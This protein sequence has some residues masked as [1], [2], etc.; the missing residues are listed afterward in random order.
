MAFTVGDG[1]G[2]PTGDRRLALGA[3]VDQLP[4]VL[5]AIAFALTVAGNRWGTYLLTP[6]P[7]LFLADLLLV[8]G[9][10][11]ALLLH[12]RHYRLS[13]WALLSYGLILGYVVLILGLEFVFVP[14]QDRYFAVRDAAPFLYLALVPALAMALRRQ[15]A[16]SAVYFVRAVTALAVVGPLL[17]HVGLVEASPSFLLGSEQV[18]FFEYRTDL[19]GAVIAIGF[20]AWSGWPALG[21]RSHLTVQLIYAF[22]AG[23]IFLSR[24]GMVA[25]AVGIIVL[26]L[27]QRRWIRGSLV[28][29]AAL[30]LLLLGLVIGPWLAPR[31]EVSATVSAP[32]VETL[33]PDEAQGTDAAVALKD[34]AA[35]VV[36]PEGGWAQ[37]FGRVGTVAARLDTWSDIVTGMARDGTWVLGGAAGSDYLYELCTG[38][39]EAPTVL[40]YP[41][42]GPKCAVDDY[43]PEPVVRDPHNWILNIAITHGVLG[44]LL[45]SGVL[46]VT[47]W[48]GR[49]S[50]IF[51]LSAWTIGFFLISGLTFLISAGYALVPMAVAAAWIVSRAGLVAKSS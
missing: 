36:D 42:S 23:V 9:A 17:V 12:G 48:R 26:G 22:V 39:P 30:G 11:S 37:V 8:L 14:Q 3:M 29:L 38:L 35:S 18:L 50:E 27:L 34:D 16:R 6:V 15:G 28:A 20:V 31:A 45:F 47:L 51:R 33:S 25:V 32:I 43:G 49:R 2:Q 41:E 13:R 40:P 7:G 10:V 46:G 24:S 4:L 44:V 21:V 1:D 5:I 19:T